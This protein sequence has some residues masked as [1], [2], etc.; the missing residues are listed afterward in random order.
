[1]RQKTRQVAA[2]L[3]KEAPNHQSAAA[4]LYTRRLCRILQRRGSYR[5]PKN[6]CIQQDRDDP[7][8]KNKIPLGEDAVTTEDTTAP[9]VASADGDIESGL[10]AGTRTNN[11]NMVRRPRPPRDDRVPGAFHPDGRNARDA[12]TLSIFTEDEEQSVIVAP[13]HSTPSSINNTGLTEEVSA[14]LVNTDEENRKVQERVDE[15]VQRALEQQALEMEQNTGV[16]H[17]VTG[18]WCSSRVK[19]MIAFCLFLAAV[20]ITL[21]IVLPRVLE[22]EPMSP[23]PGLVDLLS[24]ESFDGGEALSTPSTPQNDALLWLA[25]NTD[26]EYYSNE[27]KVQRYSLATLYYSTTG[28]MWKDKDG[29]L[30]D[31]DECSG[32]HNGAPEDDRCSNEALREFR[33]SLNKLN[34]TIPQ[35]LS[36]LSSLSTCTVRTC[37]LP[38]V[39]NKLTCFLFQHCF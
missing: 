2:V 23:L 12:S 8:E 3:E 6:R 25:N 26:L 11:E 13:N 33:L 37:P 4:P 31:V 1:V 20:A 36:L 9:S 5:C 35:E 29:W 15:E 27:R 10:V 24:A 30:S 38:R 32:W 21:G 14:T 18:F 22:P 34:G 7:N 19:I 39:E 16:A 28:L 17:V